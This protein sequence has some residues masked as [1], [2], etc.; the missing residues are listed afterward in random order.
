MKKNKSNPF[1]KPG[2]VKKSLIA[3]CVRAMP[4]AGRAPALPARPEASKKYF[5]F[6]AGLEVSLTL[7]EM[8]K[9]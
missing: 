1:P 4:S 3:Y 2:K 5:T 9:Q 8:I 6:P 7:K